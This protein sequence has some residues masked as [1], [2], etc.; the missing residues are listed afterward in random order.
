MT[1]HA[2]LVGLFGVTGLPVDVEKAH[3]R[4]QTFLSVV[5]LT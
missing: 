5:C 4:C 1:F 2:T 3:Q